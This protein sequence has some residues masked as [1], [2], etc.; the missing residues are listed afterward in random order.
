MRESILIAILAT[1]LPAT[2]GNRVT[3]TNDDV[4]RLV[5]AGFADTVVVQSVEANAGRYDLSAGGLEWLRNAG[6]V[7]KV[8]AA[9]ARSNEP[10]RAHLRILDPG[11]Y[12]TRGD[13]YAIVP[14]ETVT[15]RGATTTIDAGG[16]PLT[17]LTLVGRT[18]NPNSRIL[19][20]RR[21]ELLIVCDAGRSSSEFQLLRAET[22][23]EFRLFV[24]QAAVRDGTLLAFASLEFLP[25]VQDFTFDLGV[26]IP[27]ASLRKGEYGLISS[28]FFV[29]GRVV[30]SSAIHTFS[31][32]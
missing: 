5:K 22:K 7:E 30:A 10:S 4:A 25:I 27:L 1:A 12:A 23:D 26:R 2:E 15:W 11:I 13:A 32:D 28:N 16:V 18:E 31:I 6:V 29:D 19:L 21:A 3:L 8:I 17:R 20:S 9:M 24:A 14:V